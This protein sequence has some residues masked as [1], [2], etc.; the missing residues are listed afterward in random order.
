MRYSEDNSKTKTHKGDKK[1]GVFNSPS[2]SS[3]NTE[4]K[5][6]MGRPSPNCY[7]E[8]KSKRYGHT[9]EWCASLDVIC[10]CVRLGGPNLH[11]YKVFTT[12]GRKFLFAHKLTLVDGKPSLMLT[13]PVGLVH[14]EVA[15]LSKAMQVWHG[16]RAI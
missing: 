9:V 2:A 8:V 11:L 14:Y 7:Y 13:V 6:G 12:T 3:T 10:E 1:G 5:K 4:R 15:K 16:N